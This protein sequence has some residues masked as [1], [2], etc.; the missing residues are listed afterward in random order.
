MPRFVFAAVFCPVG[1]DWGAL[2][3]V[4]HQG[5]IVVEADFLWNPVGGDDVFRENRL[6]IGGVGWDSL[7]DGGPWR[8]DRL[9]SIW[10][11]TRVESQHFESESEAV[12]Y[13]P[14]LKMVCPVFVFFC[15]K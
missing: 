13:H 15:L 14:D 2:G 9:E 3:R 11:V 5:A 4:E 7:T 6:W 10:P 1:R 8:V 12:P